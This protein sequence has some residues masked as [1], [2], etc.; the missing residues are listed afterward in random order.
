MAENEILKPQSRLDANSVAASRALD[1][2]RGAVNAERQGMQ[3]E[4]ALQRKYR[5]AVRNEDYGGAAAIS[6]TLAQTGGSTVGPVIRK[7]ESERMVAGQRAIDR[8]D[9]QMK[10]RDG[11]VG[12]DGKPQVNA[13]TQQGADAVA[14]GT[15]AVGSTSVPG[16][17]EAVP[18][19]GSGFNPELSLEESEQFALD[20]ANAIENKA[21][22]PQV[23]TE[24][25][26]VTAASLPPEKP[27]VSSK[28]LISNNEVAEALAGATKAKQ[29][30]GRIDEIFA[31]LK[32]SA[33]S[34]YGPK[35][36]IAQTPRFQ[37]KEVPK[38]AIRTRTG[39]SVFKN[40]DV[41]STAYWS[42]DP[43]QI[44]S[45]KKMEGEG[46]SAYLGADA[47]DPRFP[48]MKI[49]QESEAMIKDAYSARNAKRKVYRALGEIG[50]VAK[51]EF[52]SDKETRKMHQES[53]D[54]EVIWRA[55][56]EGV[57]LTE[58][59]RVRGPQFFNDYQEAKN[60]QA[61]M[62]KDWF[63]AELLKGKV[64]SLISP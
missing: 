23:I 2:E 42:I 29:A 60:V 5:R 62:K 45:M 41:G 27:P 57:D 30:G 53:V 3:T 40:P 18:T 22:R 17:T 35:G 24:R 4:R 7:A 50:L 6:Q 1:A 48:V 13:G 49:I 46:G 58:Y 63:Q 37:K 9:Q 44:A 51:D 19:R 21:A 32:P 64:A 33:P 31:S 20:S 47:S 59:A 8:T 39:D 15:G 12:P 36:D 56:K 52:Y 55:A 11:G 28:P 25:S 54:H 61:E 26:P 10:I 16:S 14:A 34:R 38:A 43:D